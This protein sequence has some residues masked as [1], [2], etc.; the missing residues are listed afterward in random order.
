MSIFSPIVINLLVTGNITDPYYE[1]CYF[2]KVLVALQKI[3][4]LIAFSMSVPHLSDYVD[5][6]AAVLVVHLFS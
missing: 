4:F 3:Q 6:S 2:P 1:A 5:I